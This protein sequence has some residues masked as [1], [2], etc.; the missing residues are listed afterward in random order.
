MSELISWNQGTP[1]AQLPVAIDYSAALALRRH[2][3]ALTFTS[4]SV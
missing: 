1:P 2:V 3:G 4:A